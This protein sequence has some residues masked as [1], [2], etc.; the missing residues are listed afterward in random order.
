MKNLSRS[1]KKNLIVAYSDFS[2]YNAPLYV[3]VRTAF[4]GIRMRWW[5]LTIVIGLAIKQKTKGK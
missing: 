4:S 2:K 5:E 3:K 1:F